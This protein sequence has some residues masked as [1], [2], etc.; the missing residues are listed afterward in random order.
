MKNKYD[1]S[2]IFLYAVGKERLLPEEFRKQI[3]Y[4]TISN[5]RRM[6]YSRY[7]GHEFRY[8][9]DEAF[10][11]AELNFHYRKMKKAMLGFAKTWVELSAFIKPLIKNAGKDRKMQMK[12]LKAIG[13]M[14]SHIG[15]DRSLKLLGVSR[16]LYQQWVLATRFDCFDSY[17]ALC[18]KRHPH[19]LQLKE[20]ETI[21]RVLRSSEFDHWPIVSIASLCLRKKKLTASLYTW[22]KY[23]RLLGITR[24]LVGKIRKTVG[25]RAKCPNEYL[26]VDTTFYL[27]IDGKEICITF[28]M[29]N[30]SKMILG[31][32]VA[33]R[34]SF[35]L[36]TE[37]LSNALAVIMKHPDQEHSYLVADGGSEN[38]NKQ[39]EEFIAKLSDHKITKIIA[40][41]DIVFS[42][43]PVEAIHRTIKGRYLRNRKFE[44]ISVLTKYLEWAVHDYN[45]LR[46]HYRHR[47][48]TP[49][50]VYFNTP[51]GFD[52]RK[53]V[54]NAIA[55]RVRNNKCAKCTECQGVCSK[56]R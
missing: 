28:V 18:V 23:A 35:A 44:N 46:P 49:Q 36:I 15:L 20:I 5:W 56:K 32:A 39:V 47:P 54:K 10:N 11:N 51:L 25:L 34:L 19:Q 41:K 31:F 17:T 43:S 29:D 9:F 45:V 42:N 22:Y 24:K 4:T 55:T 27:I 6:D 14:K 40:L 53:R 33:E 50:E 1:T 2:V 12:I 30:Y 16:T 52:I 37:A 13:Y 26:H 48:R 7:T 8:F 3:P 21:K 38:H